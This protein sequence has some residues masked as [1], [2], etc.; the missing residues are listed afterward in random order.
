MASELNRCPASHR[1]EP[2]SL[3]EQLYLVWFLEVYDMLADP[4]YPERCL[5]RAQKE[6]AY[7]VSTCPIG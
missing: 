6:I 4:D 1:L 7:G 3:P 5:K 2:L